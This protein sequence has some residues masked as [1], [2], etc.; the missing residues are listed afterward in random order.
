MQEKAED[1]LINHSR[2]YQATCSFNSS[3][4]V[5]KSEEARLL[6]DYSA[7]RLK[8]MSNLSGESVLKDEIRKNI[9]TGGGFPQAKVEEMMSGVTEIPAELVE[10][11]IKMEKARLQFCLSED[12]DYLDLKK[13]QNADILQFLPHLN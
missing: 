2:A 13:K 8:K 10:Q 7:D 5:P 4:P 3:K 9:I 12:V 1:L 11:F 6:K